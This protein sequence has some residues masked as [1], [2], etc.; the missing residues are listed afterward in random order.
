MQSQP[1]RH[2]KLWIL[3]LDPTTLLRIP[4]CYYG[5]YLDS[6]ML[7]RIPAATQ[8]THNVVVTNHNIIQFRHSQRYSSRKNFVNRGHSTGLL[9]VCPHVMSP[10]PGFPCRAPSSSLALVS[11]KP[12]EDK[13]T[14]C[15]TVATPNGCQFIGCEFTHKKSG[16]AGVRRGRALSAPSLTKARIW[17]A[18]G[19]LASPFGWTGIAIEEKDVDSA[20]SSNT[21]CNWFE[22]VKGG[23]V[24]QVRRKRSIITIPF[25]TPLDSTIAPSRTDDFLSPRS[26]QCSGQRLWLGGTMCGDTSL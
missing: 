4:V 2:Y 26:A 9:V 7:L 22:E 6:T 18:E 11:H 14:A 1:S 10:P 15:L 13:R 23:S 25:V 19:L 3:F 24:Y 12:K 17:S 8:S 21:V 5:W 16:R 20:A